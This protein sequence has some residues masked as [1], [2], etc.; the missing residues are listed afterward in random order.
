MRLL[1]ALLACAAFAGV[2][3]A[4][5]PESLDRAAISAGISS[6][7]PKVVA[8]GEKAPDVKGKVKIKVVVEPAGTVATAAIVETPDDT[9]GACVSAAVKTAKFGA[10][11]NGGTFSYPFVF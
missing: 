6:V 10:T 1:T 7:K 2:A 4:D 8:C 3:F 11:K 9:L 5:V